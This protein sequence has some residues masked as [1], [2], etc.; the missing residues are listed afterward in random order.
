MRRGML[1]DLF[2]GVVAKRLTRVETITA[3]SNQ[4]E[5]QGIKP[6]RALMAPVATRTDR[7]A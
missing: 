6:L 1:S 3:T 7:A 5:F 4:H 2:L